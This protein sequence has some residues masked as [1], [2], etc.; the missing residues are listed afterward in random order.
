MRKGDY[1]NNDNHN[2]LIL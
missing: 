1:Q 2:D